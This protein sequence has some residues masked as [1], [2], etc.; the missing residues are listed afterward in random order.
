MRKSFDGLSGLVTSILGRNPL[1][2]SLYIFLSKHRNRMKCLVWY[3]PGFGLFYKRLEKGTFQLR[4]P[5]IHCF[6]CFLGL[7]FINPMG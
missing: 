5:F 1:E 6:L 2:G 4:L 7:Y 3:R